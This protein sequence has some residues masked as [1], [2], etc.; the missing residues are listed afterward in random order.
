MLYGARRH[1][2]FFLRLAPVE[3]DLAATFAQKADA[4][5]RAAKFPL[6]KK[7][8]ETIND[9]GWEEP[10]AE[11]AGR[12]NCY[13][14]WSAAHKKGYIGMDEHMRYENAKWPSS[15]ER[16][17]QHNVDTYRTSSEDYYS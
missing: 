3:I 7:Y 6:L 5:W 14:R 2:S 11:E 17:L 10:S 12:R 8:F 1:I 9:L 15:V 4:A 16:D 13:T